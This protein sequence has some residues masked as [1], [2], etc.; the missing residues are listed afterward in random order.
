MAKRKRSAQVFVMP[1]VERRDMNG[2]HCDSNTVLQAAID[3]G[4]TDAM[5]I[6]KD[7]QGNLYLASASPDTDKA[8]AM[9]MRAVALLV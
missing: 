6:G 3:N 8:V 4:V 9:L 5:V 2:Q 7:R 1:G